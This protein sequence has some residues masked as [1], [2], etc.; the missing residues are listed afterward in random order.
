MTKKNKT[1]KRLTAAESLFKDK[2]QE[3]ELVGKKMWTK[4]SWPFKLI[5]N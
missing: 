5:I 3:K 2:E 4:K 1:E